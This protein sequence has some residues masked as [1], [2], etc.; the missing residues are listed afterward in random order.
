LKCVV[1]VILATIVLA[2]VKCGSV[3][4]VAMYNCVTVVG[5]HQVACLLSYGEFF[6]CDDYSEEK[7][8]TKQKGRGT[9][10]IL[11]LC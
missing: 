6:R 10:A 8:V 7:A 4:H 9:C 3:Y 11:S 5:P 2:F 1:V